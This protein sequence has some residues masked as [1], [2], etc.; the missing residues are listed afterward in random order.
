MIYFDFVSALFVDFLNYVI[1]KIRVEDRRA[2]AEI[3]H[4]EKDTSVH[5]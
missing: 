4:D 1:A 2:D 5:N 3:T